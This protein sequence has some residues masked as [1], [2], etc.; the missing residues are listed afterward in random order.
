M[1]VLLGNAGFIWQDTTGERTFNLR[2]PLRATRTAVR[3]VRFVRESVDLATRNVTVVGSGV[4]E[5]VADIRYEDAVGLGNTTH[6]LSHFLLFGIRG[7]LV[8]YFPDLATT[9]EFFDCLLIEPGG[10]GAGGTAGVAASEQ[11]VAVTSMDADRGFP[12][13]E[14]LSVQIRLRKTDGSAFE[15]FTSS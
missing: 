9:S 4:H 7:G 6:I 15:Q 8:Q 1:A 10:G 12:G 14:D 5:I 13:F 2:A 3:Q 11:T